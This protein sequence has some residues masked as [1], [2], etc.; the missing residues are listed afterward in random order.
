METIGKLTNVARNFDTD[1]LQVTFEIDTKPDFEE[2]KGELEIVAHKRR[3]KRSLNANAYLWVLCQKIAEK[4]GNTHREAVYLDMLRKYSR[5]FTFLIVKEKALPRVMEEFRTCI[6]LGEVKVN[7]QEG[8]Q[9][10]VFFGTSTFDSK[11]MAVLIDGV[12]TEAKELDIEV[13]PNDEIER[14]KNK[15]GQ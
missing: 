14:L 8:H 7:G 12:I 9:I 5:A 3:K 6:D 10:Q 11:E 4:V 15:W 13:L 1:K 2:L